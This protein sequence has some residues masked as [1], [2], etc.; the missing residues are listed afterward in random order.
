MRRLLSRVT[1][2]RIYARNLSDI[3]QVFI[4]VLCS[5]GLLADVQG[6]VCLPL[7]QQAAKMK[8]MLVASVAIGTNAVFTKYGCRNAMRPIDGKLAWLPIKGSQEMRVIYVRAPCK[9]LSASDRCHPAWSGHHLSANPWC[10][11][12]SVA[13]RWHRASVLLRG[14]VT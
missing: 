6:A 11:N 5:G 1:F 3:N 2:C 12:D 14:R 8:S 4:V 10:H 13:C 7:N 9:L